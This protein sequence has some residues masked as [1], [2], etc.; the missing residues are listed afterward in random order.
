VL[1]LE[2]VVEPVVP[3]WVVAVTAEG[4]ALAEA[5]ALSK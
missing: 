5:A 3:G 2:M 4:V 1:P